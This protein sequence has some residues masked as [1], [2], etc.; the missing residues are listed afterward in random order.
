MNVL[1][2]ARV[3][4]VQM[5]SGPAVA[6]N[7]EE[8]ARLIEMAVDRGAQLVALPEYFPIFGLDERDKVKVREEEGAGP[9]QAFLAETARRHRIWLVGGSVPLVAS[10][11]DK[12]LN[13]TLVYDD[14]GRLAARYDKMHLF[15][16]EHGKESY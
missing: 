10:V 15:A 7:L 11:S 13:S 9:I 4:A 8:A 2:K 6:G 12:V 3:A 16:F 14:A 5:T 1:T